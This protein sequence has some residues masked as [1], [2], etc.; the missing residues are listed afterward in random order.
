MG[1]VLS[2]LFGGPKPPPLPPPAAPPPTP[3][4][5]A[6]AETRQRQRRLAGAR[7]SSFLT[8]GLGAGLGSA[9]VDT[10]QKSLLGV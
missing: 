6:V 1:Q 10:A 8:A 7:S 9:G 2:N 3:A 5:P 4:D